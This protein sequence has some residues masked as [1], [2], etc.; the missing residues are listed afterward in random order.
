M[1]KAEEI[2]DQLWTLPVAYYHYTFNACTSAASDPIRGFESIISVY[3]YLMSLGDPRVS[4]WPLMKSPWPTVFIALT[5]LLIVRWGPV[6]MANRKP[7]EIRPLIL[8]YNA[9]VALLNLYIGVELTSKLNYRINCWTKEM[10]N[11][12]LQIAATSTKLD[13]SWTCEP[14]DYSDNPLAIRVASALW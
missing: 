5:Y 11:V 12:F 1:A 8:I 3:D 7:L 4:H 13:F 2:F 14:V 10:N 9:A 6:F